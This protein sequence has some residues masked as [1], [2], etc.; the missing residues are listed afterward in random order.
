MMHPCKCFPHAS[1]VATLAKLSERFFSIATTL[2]TFI[3]ISF[4]VRDIKN[5]VERLANVEEKKIN[6]GMNKGIT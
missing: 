4:P 1:K 2:T 5:H 6:L 3:I